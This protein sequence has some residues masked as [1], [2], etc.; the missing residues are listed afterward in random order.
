MWVRELV[1]D[2]ERFDLKWDWKKRKKLGLWGGGVVGWGSQ[3]V[4]WSWCETGRWRGGDWGGLL[5]QVCRWGWS[6]RLGSFYRQRLLV[7]GPWH[8]EG[9]CLLQKL[10][11]LLENPASFPTLVSVA[12]LWMKQLLRDFLLAHLCP[13]AVYELTNHDVFLRWQQVRYW[14]WG[15]GVVYSHKSQGTVH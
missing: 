7:G 1:R 6:C 8:Q 11:V 3:G 15:G 2:E 9:V 5:A 4:E 12:P 14:V 10:P 13:R